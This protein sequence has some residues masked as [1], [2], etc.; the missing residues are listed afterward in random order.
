MY[1][2]V[3]SKSNVIIVDQRL[4]KGTKSYLVHP[5]KLDNL[6][7]TGYKEA[8]IDQIRLL[9]VG[10]IRVEKGIFYLTKILKNEEDFL[11]LNI[12][13]AEVDSKNFV[14]QKN[15]KINLIEPNEDKL[16]KFY[17]E[18]N[19]FV[20]PSYTEGH[21][22]VLLESLARLKPVIIFEEIKHVIGEKKGIFVSKRNKDNF[23]ELMN[24]IKKNYNSIQTEMKKNILPLKKD[25]IEDFV[26][27]LEK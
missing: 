5:S 2:I 11:E 8:S 15:I 4:Y 9:Y 12:V 13:G 17:D 19:I 27:I 21:P 14:N 1:K 20:L 26:K 6:W 7:F 10:R 23:F 25:Y 22:M 24:Y 16:I 18:C 3:T